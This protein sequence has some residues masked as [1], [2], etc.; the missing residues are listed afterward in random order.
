MNDPIPNLP[1]KWANFLLNEIIRCPPS[2]TVDTDFVISDAYEP[3]HV[4]RSLPQDDTILSRADKLQ[5]HRNMIRK[6][7]L[8]LTDY[9]SQA[10][11]V[12]NEYRPAWNRR[13]TKCLIVCFQHCYQVL[14]LTTDC[15]SRIP[16]LV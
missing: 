10:R 16:T 5:Y 9:L 3:T 12:D 6:Y 2:A 4:V 15:S 7:E 8:L 13:A 14:T 11:S 1:A